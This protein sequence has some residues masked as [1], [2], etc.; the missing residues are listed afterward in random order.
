M[1]GGRRQDSFGNRSRSQRFNRNGTTKTQQH[2]RYHTEFSCCCTYCKEPVMH[3]DFG[4][5]FNSSRYTG[6]PGFPQPGSLPYTADELRALADRMDASGGGRVD[7]E[8]LTSQQSPHAG[9]VS[10]KPHASTENRSQRGTA[11][12]SN[13]TA[14]A[15]N[16]GTN[17]RASGS[18]PKQASAAAPRL[19]AKPML[20]QDAYIKRQQLR[21]LL[22]KRLGQVWDALKAM[23][24][25]GAKRTPESRQSDPETT[26]GLFLPT[27]KGD[28]EQSFARPLS[29]KEFGVEKLGHLLARECDDVL[30]EPAT[31]AQFMPMVR[32]H[33][34][35]SARFPTSSCDTPDIHAHPACRL[36]A[37][38]LC[39]R[40]GRPRPQRACLGANKLQL[41]TKTPTCM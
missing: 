39:H 16:W 20:S 14:A 33:L 6:G 12:Q 15:G 1:W 19:D 11:S 36:K 13:A 41:S 27:I 28:F 29:Y 17:S 4:A 3:A 35:A 34:A 5:P 37:S 8:M 7:H 2:R 9:R 23:E 38:R 30:Q 24:E 31:V 18:A 40:E 21:W 26:P 22:K 25:K 32:C 10:Q